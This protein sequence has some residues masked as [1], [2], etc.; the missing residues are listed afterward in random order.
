MYFGE[1]DLGPRR[2]GLLKVEVEV[3]DHGDY[4]ST[5]R[6]EVAIY[7]RLGRAKEYTEIGFIVAFVVDERM[8]QT[9]K[10][11]SWIQEL[12]QDQYQYDDDDQTRPLR[13]VCQALFTTSGAPRAILSESRQELEVDTFVF[14]DNFEIYHTYRE[15]GAGVSPMRMFL[16]MIPQVVGRAAGSEEPVTAY[17][18][19]RARS[20]SVKINRKKTD[21]E[22][23]QALARTYR[24]NNFEVWLQGD[25]TV[26]DSLTV[27][28]R[29]L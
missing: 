7:Q 16:N 20:A 28:G 29:V 22:V 26:E 15:R 5:K 19:C 2:S 23:E 1:E 27:M 3:Q 21:V 6:L 10:T 4:E 24:R 12:V 18:L 8:K 13:E 17:L 11:E 25:P 9:K 14:I